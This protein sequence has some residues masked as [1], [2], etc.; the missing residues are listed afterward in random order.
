M[1]PSCKKFWVKHV[2]FANS[3]PYFLI[4][5]WTVTS[6]L[7]VYWIML[8][9]LSDPVDLSLFFQTKKHPP[10]HVKRPMNAFMVFSLMQRREIIA[11]NPDS[12]NAEI[13]KVSF[14]LLMPT[15]RV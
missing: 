7:P 13:S 4:Q 14:H 6:P 9:K 5:L 3:F 8:T 11:R 1:K 12:H 15:H 10:N 2:I